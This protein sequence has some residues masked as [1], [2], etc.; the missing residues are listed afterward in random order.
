MEDPVRQR[1]DFMVILRLMHKNILERDGELS[2]S[3]TLSPPESVLTFSELQ[4]KLN[5]LE[6]DQCFLTNL[7]LELTKLREC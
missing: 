5:G 7:P 1:E 2:A 3:K 4:D 6:V